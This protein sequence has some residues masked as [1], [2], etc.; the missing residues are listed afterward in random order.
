[1][2]KPAPYHPI[3]YAHLISG[4]KV[5]KMRGEG[6][7]ERRKGVADPKE[8]RRPYLF[9]GRKGTP[10][11]GRPGNPKKLNCKGVRGI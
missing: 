11:S 3:G 9:G 6:K 2:R 4:H 1:M 5:C 8:T 10:H 7:S